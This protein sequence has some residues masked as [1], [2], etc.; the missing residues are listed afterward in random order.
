[1]LKFTLAHL[2]ALEEVEKTGVP[3][4]VEILR[5][6]GKIPLGTSSGTGLAGTVAS[7]PDIRQNP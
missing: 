7:R 5:E 6:E 3:G 2:K 4:L 1:M